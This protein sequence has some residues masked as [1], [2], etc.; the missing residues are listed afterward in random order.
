MVAG[1]RASGTS[2]PSC[3]PPPGPGPAIARNLSRSTPSRGSEGQGTLLAARP[4]GF[5]VRAVPSQRT[6]GALYR[7]FLCSVLAIASVGL[8]VPVPAAPMAWTH[9]ANASV[10]RSPAHS[11]PALKMPPEPGAA[12]VAEARGSLAR[13]VAPQTSASAWTPLA[14]PQGLAAAGLVYDAADGYVLLFGGFTV[15]G[16]Q[17]VWE[18][19]TWE[20]SRGNWSLMHSMTAPSPRSGTG[21]VYDAADGYVLLFGSGLQSRT[22]DTWTYSHGTWNQ[23]R[24]VHSPP[25]SDWS[26]AYDVKDG[27]V[28]LYSGWCGGPCANHETWTYSKGKWTSAYRTIEPPADSGTPISYDS[29]DGYVVAWVGNE[30]V[31]GGHSGTGY[32]TNETWTFSAGN[33]T[34]RTNVSRPTPSSRYYPTLSDDPRDGCLLLFGGQGGTTGI[35]GDT[36]EYANGAWKRVLGSAHPS[37]RIDSGMTFDNSTRTA[38]LFGGQGT[39]TKPFLAD[40]WR[41]ATG[42]WTESNANTLPIPRAGFGIAYDSHDGYALMFGGRSGSTFLGDTW[43]FATGHWTRLNPAMS[44]SP[45]TGA[46][47]S[48]DRGLAVIRLFGGYNGS[49][50]NDSWTFSAG[51][52]SRL[53]GSLQPSG[54]AY[55]SFAFFPPSNESILFGG[56][57]MVY[58]GDTWELKNGVWSRIPLTA[59]YAPSA[60]YGGTMA[61]DSRAGSLIFF[62]GFNGV[63]WGDTWA[64]NGSNWSVI[65]SFSSPGARYFSATAY[66]VSTQ[67]V[68]L[69]GG[70]NGA[71]LRDTWTYG[72]GSWTRLHPSTS[73]SGRGLAG[74]W[75]DPIVG[76]IV[77]AG[78][79]SGRSLPLSD[80]WFS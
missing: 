41:F 36:W 71:A 43:A 8:L 42:N 16:G 14:P 20:Y 60:R 40:T 27:Y 10:V 12:A 35:L 53:S 30:I 76:S 66:D 2:N 17:N 28:V 72:S 37:S 78:G 34:N 26:A 6:A 69:F 11:G 55:A 4:S 33:W 22:N 68:V 67:R 24:I 63:Y 47:I 61:Y 65:V 7:R 39:G 46:A 54:R 29:A 19:A 56:V 80:V 73:P 75:F 38:I 25:V 79:Y 49:Y 1:A 32:N 45:R 23:L 74:I 21:L 9:L 58:L 44:P 62:G 48:Y 57:G 31:G 5:L 3:R 15:A 64:F 13:H 50:L 59:P 18:N 70:Y 52:W 51:S 77:V